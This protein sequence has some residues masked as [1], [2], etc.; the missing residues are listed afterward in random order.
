M[1]EIDTNI[2]TDLDEL[3]RQISQRVQDIEER[4]LQEA[5]GSNLPERLIQ[6]QSSVSRIVY[7]FVRAG[8]FER[9]KLTV[10][11]LITLRVKVENGTLDK[12]YV[13]AIT[14]GRIADEVPSMGADL[15]KWLSE[16]SWSRAKALGEDLGSSD[17]L[18]EGILEKIAGDA[19]D[20]E[21]WYNQSDPEMRPMPGEFKELGKDIK[22]LLILRVMRPDRLPVA[23]S[24]Y[25]QDNLGEEFVVQ[26]PFNMIATYRDTTNK[27]PVLFV[28]YP[29]VDPTS[30]VEDLGREKGVTAERGLFANISMGQGQESRA[31]E[32]IKK[33]GKVG[34]W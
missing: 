5:G 26:P 17:P 25:V 22:R 28:L 11:T 31:D 3:E 16:A 20:W 33:L 8:L 27:T 12:I 24:E 15:S 32:T 6:L 9:D 23:L 7:N 30:W 18:F 19:E 10:A 2:T 34:G 14:R 1:N 29:G 21:E 13:D 4:D